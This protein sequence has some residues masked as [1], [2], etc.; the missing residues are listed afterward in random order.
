MKDIE[1]FKKLVS[2]KDTDE[3][4]NTNHNKCVE[5]A[6]KRNGK[7]CCAS[8]PC[9]LNA[10]DI[11][12]EITEEKIRNLLNT[13]LVTIDCY[14]ENLGWNDPED[15]DRTYYLRMRAKKDDIPVAFIWTG[16]CVALDN[17]G[18]ILS[19]NN[20]P[21]YGRKFF[22]DTVPSGVNTKEAAAKS[23]LPYQHI[24]AKIVSEYDVNDP[25]E[26]M[27]DK[28]LEDFLSHLL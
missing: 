13:G 8:M 22:C 5:C 20:R 7:T 25:L 4:Q 24:L 16:R 18:C 9:E 3:K 21:Y 26:D 28:M 10:S 23:F 19:Y 27:V 17:N 11:V 1:T 12:G 14:E 6:A 15:Q 2:N